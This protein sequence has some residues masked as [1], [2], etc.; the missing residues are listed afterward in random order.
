VIAILRKYHR[1][2]AIL[3]T[4]VACSFF[5]SIGVTYGEPI[6]SDV[7]CV[8]V[9]LR[10]SQSTDESTKGTWNLATLYYLGRIDGSGRQIDLVSQIRDDF[11]KVTRKN[12]DHYRG[13]CASQFSARGRDLTKIGKELQ[14]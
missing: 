2:L 3:T 7:L 4:V 8:I 11:H 13:K 14:Q 10:M 5:S 1:R 9:S 12:F 6:D